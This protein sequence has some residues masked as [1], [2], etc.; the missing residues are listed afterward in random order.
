VGFVRHLR[1]AGLPVGTDR[2]LTFCRAVA[3]LDPLDPTDLRLAAGATLVS[4][5]DDLDALDRAF[6]QYFGSSAGDPIAPPAT[7]PPP[8]VEPERTTGVAVAIDRSAAEGEGERGDETAV[9]VTASESE[10]LRR[11]D[12]AEMNEAERRAASLVIRRVVLAAPVRRSRRHRSAPRGPRLDLRRTLLRSLR[13][14]GEPFRRA[15][16][17]RQVRPR[18]VVLLLDVSGSMAPYARP[19]MAFAHAV[20]RSGVRVE[21]FCFGTRLTRIT[22]QVR[23]PDPGR[24]MAAVGDVVADWEGGTLI[25]R[26]LGELLDRWASRSGLRGAVVVLCSDGLERGDPAVLASRMVRLK[27]LAH[28][29]VWVNPLSGSPRYRPL[30][31][32]MAASLPHIDVF[33]PGHNLES[34]ETLAA[35]LDSV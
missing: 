6:D 35:S 23:T 2:I 20:A 18:P 5:P 33:L 30:A 24:A 17:T 7:A 27:R 16:R 11:K 25:G 4:G 29:V 12:F 34:L 1:A 28:R 19:L 13:T 31:R 10:R 15:W 22:P 3:A 14:E 8:R 32:G 26:S 9:R 21:A